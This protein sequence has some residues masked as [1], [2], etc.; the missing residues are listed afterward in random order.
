M[1]RERLA[2]RL[3]EHERSTA[4]A[5][6]AAAQARDCRVVKCHLMFYDL[7]CRMPLKPNKNDDELPN[8]RHDDDDVSTIM[9]F[10]IVF[11]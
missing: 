6:R 11:Q 7:C 2:N 5:A 9:V 3:A 4:D 8:L 10:L 1:E